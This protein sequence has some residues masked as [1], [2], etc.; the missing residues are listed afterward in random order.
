MKIVSLIL[1]LSGWLI[2]LAAIAL[3][4]SVP[5]RATFLVA[6]LGIQILGVVLLLRAHL[7]P[8]RERG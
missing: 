1:L 7:T 4:A 5:S 3:L 6:G 2:V 8:R